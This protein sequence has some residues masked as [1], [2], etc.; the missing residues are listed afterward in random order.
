MSKRPP[1]FDNQNSSKKKSQDSNIE[2]NVTHAALL[3]AAG[4]CWSGLL[5]CQR[6]KQIPD[7]YSCSA[8]DDNWLMELCCKRCQKSFQV[9][10]T[11]ANNRKQFIDMNDVRNH[12]KLLS[13]RKRVRKTEVAEADVA[14][15]NE[16]SLVQTETDSVVPM[17]KYL[18]GSNLQYFKM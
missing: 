6:C 18:Q 9:C 2:E 5:A 17:D 11:C 14:D 7:S 15:N 3:Q 12:S 10:T 8:S 13:H 1:S 4:S 16:I